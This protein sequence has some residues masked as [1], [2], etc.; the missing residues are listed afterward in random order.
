MGV[1]D[2]G[3][4]PRS[5][6]TSLKTILTNPLVASIFLFGLA[7]SLRNRISPDANE[8]DVKFDALKQ[9]VSEQRDDYIGMC[10]IAKGVLSL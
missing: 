3:K 8:L 9:A 7:L 10:V 4:P 1:K 5:S 6:E 2:K